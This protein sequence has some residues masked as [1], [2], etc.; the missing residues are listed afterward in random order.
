MKCISDSENPRSY[1]HSQ[2]ICLLLWLASKNTIFK[3]IICC[4]LHCYFSCSSSKHESW[5]FFLYQFF[6]CSYTIVLLNDKI[7]ICLMISIFLLTRTPTK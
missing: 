6:L 4:E 5:H 1:N 7:N 3:A 2:Y